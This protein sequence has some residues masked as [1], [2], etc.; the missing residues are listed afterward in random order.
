MTAILLGQA[1]MSCLGYG[2]GLLRPPWEHSRLLQSCLHAAAQ[3]R[4]SRCPAASPP[5]APLRL[6]AQSEPPA[7]ASR[8]SLTCSGLAIG[9]CHIPNCSTDDA[10]LP[11][12]GVCSRLSRAC[13]EPRTVLRAL[14][15]LNPVLPPSWT[16]VLTPYP[17]PQSLRKSPGS[18]M[19]HP[20]IFRERLSS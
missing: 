19:L 14:C 15:V 1:T 5:A 12:N 20:S 16:Y 18:T 11:Q 6:R 2:N 9:L 7:R 8:S 13:C 10:I 17:V 3:S 4:E